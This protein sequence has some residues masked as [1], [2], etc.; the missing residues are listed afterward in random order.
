MGFKGTSENISVNRFSPPSKKRQLPSPQLPALRAEVPALALGKRQGFLLLFFR[1]SQL[2]AFRCRLLPWGP[3]LPSI[4]ELHTAAHRCSRWVFLV[5]LRLLA[6]VH[7]FYCF[8]QPSEL[9]LVVEV[10]R[11]VDWQDGVAQSAVAL[12]SIPCDDCGR[13]RYE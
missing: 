2:A 7:P 9:S 1:P 3:A 12:A 11:I 6:D 13:F 8:L 4:E 10:H 5:T